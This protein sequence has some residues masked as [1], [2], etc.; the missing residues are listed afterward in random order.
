MKA[1]I[2]TL[3]CNVIHDGVSYSKGSECP[4]DAD[5]KAHF[6]KKGWLNR[7]MAEVV[8]KDEDLSSDENSDDVSSDDAPVGDA[9]TEDKPVVAAA[10]K[11][12]AAKKPK[13]KK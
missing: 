11:K 13:K 5:I 4:K 7:Q 12:A 10:D 9:P 8:G 3:N 2:F 6:G 1:P